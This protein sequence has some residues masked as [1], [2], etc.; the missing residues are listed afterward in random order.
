VTEA[1]WHS[2]CT[3]APPP[4]S[5]AGNLFQSLQDTLMAAMNVRKM[6]IQGDDDSD[7]EWD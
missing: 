2:F 4:P 3:A 6:A 7:D 1:D 5:N